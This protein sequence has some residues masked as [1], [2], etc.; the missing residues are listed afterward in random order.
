LQ[1]RIAVPRQSDQSGTMY[2]IRPQ[3]P[4]LNLLTKSK[5]Q[6]VKLASLQQSVTNNSKRLQPYS[7]EISPLVTHPKHELI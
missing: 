3:T 1:R 4:K 5:P 2:R 7:D 6:K